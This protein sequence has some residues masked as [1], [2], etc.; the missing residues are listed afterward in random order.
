MA[1]V[2][3]QRNCPSWPAP[4]PSSPHGGRC[5]SWAAHS[6]ADHALG[7]TAQSR[8]PA[9]K[10][11][12]HARTGWSKSGGQVRQAQA[13][14][15]SPSSPPAA[16]PCPSALASLASAAGRA[17]AITRRR[18]VSAIAAFGRRRHQDQM[19]SG[20][21]TLFD[22]DVLSARSF[23]GLFNGL[24]DRSGSITGGMP[25]VEHRASP[26]LLYKGEGRAPG[27]T[28]LDVSLGQQRRPLA[29]RSNIL[30]FPAM[31]QHL[32]F[33]SVS[34]LRTSVATPCHYRVSL[35]HSS[36]SNCLCHGSFALVATISASRK[37]T[38]FGR[39]AVVSPKSRI[40]ESLLRWEQWAEVHFAERRRKPKPLPMEEP[41]PEG[42]RQGSTLLG[43][44]VQPVDGINT[45]FR[46]G[47]DLACKC[48]CQGFCRVCSNRRH[49]AKAL[50]S[51]SIP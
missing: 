20:A 7:R 46:R 45:S 31:A 13:R 28:L 21:T 33:V 29:P 10:E 11:C 8:A 22:V 26:R 40:A 9:T 3:T 23:P 43:R 35:T 50:R 16:S 15:S 37:S 17:F 36:S 34:L 42:P 44:P 1:S 38:A 4:E 39:Q 51:N 19:G 48:V 47:S 6:L 12:R 24:L 25:L 14:S 30:R 27:P 18:T 41:H 5:S 49:L 32:R 2:R